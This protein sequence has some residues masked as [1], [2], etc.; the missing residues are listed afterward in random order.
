MT[1]NDL[2]ALNDEIA[3]LV[4][5]GVPLEQ[6]LYELGADMP[7]RMGQIAAVLAEKTARGESLENALLDQAIHLPTA[8]RS[9]VQAGVRSGRL[10]AAL[11]AVATSARRTVE[12]QRS[13]LV[14]VSYP[15]FVVS[16]VWVGFALFCAILAPRLAASM[17]AMG[18]PAHKFFFVLAWAGRWSWFWGPALPILLAIL[19]FAWWRESS[20]AS[21]LYSRSADRLFGW[22]PWMGRMMQCSRSATFLDVLALLIENQTPL[23]EAVAL[24]ASASGDYK[25]ICDARRLTEMIQKGQLQPGH[26]ASDPAFPPLMNW[27]V[28]SAGR[29][30]AL[31]PALRQSAEAYH[32]RSRMQSNLVRTLLPTLLTVVIAGGITAAYALTLFI[33]YAIMLETLSK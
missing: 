23:D 10:P 30:G 29:G 26:L 28:F 14:A 1:L 24:A 33:P 16:L 5:A 13:A 19:L 11:E 8:Y 7:G 2:I 22:L 27:L 15:L 4:R 21:V 12:T 25:T 32:R 6:G 18:I 9:V 20:G 17:L 3:A 31:V